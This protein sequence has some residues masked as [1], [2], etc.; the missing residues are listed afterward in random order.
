[1]LI[2]CPKCGFSRDVPEDKLPATASV[3]TCPKCKHKFKFR[4]SAKSTRPRDY[5][6]QPDEPSTVGHSPS[7]S[8]AAEDSPLDSQPRIP[9]RIANQ[10]ADDEEP[11]D[12][13]RDDGGRDE[14]MTPRRGRAPG[15]TVEPPEEGDIWQRL[16]SMRSD[17]HG[18]SDSD[19]RIGREED[20]ESTGHGSP[21][22][23][24]GVPVIDAPW[25]RLDK[26]G[27]LN[28]FAQT[29][30]RAMLHPQAF[31]AYM[32]LR[33]MAKP[34]AFFL[35]VG[36]IQLTAQLFWGA[37]S[38]T[39]MDLIAPRPEE[40]QTSAELGEGGYL[41]F[42]VFPLV[43]MVLVFGVTALNH[44]F[45]MA[46]RAATRGFEATFRAV[47]Y[48][49]APL[50]LALLPYVGDLVG[51]AWNLAV[52]IIAYKYIH[53]TSYTRVALAMLIPFAFML[54]LGLLSLGST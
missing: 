50:V 32:P 9:A 18:G 13:A 37:N 27:P 41:L 16:E 15:H 11:R 53:R 25:E 22:V 21:G 30:K 20:D 8:P 12:D 10:A 34:L 49:S 6:R 28:G 14:E 19:A 48:G 24:A 2:Q 47:A 39:F 1:M 31:F 29:I 43:L 26:F 5:Q 52:T 35:L 44:L 45:L 33:G 17:Q 7:R 36:C 54:S 4:E 3:A 40:A 46:T 51:L 38:M 23:E 42:V